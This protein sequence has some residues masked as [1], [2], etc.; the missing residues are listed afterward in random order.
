MIGINQADAHPRLGREDHGDVTIQIEEQRGPMTL[1]LNGYHRIRWHLTGPGVSQIERLVS[2]GYDEQL[3][4][5]PTLEP[6]F[7]EQYIVSHGDSM[8]SRPLPLLSWFD[9]HAGHC[10]AT[11]P[12]KHE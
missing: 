1:V 12:H 4:N 10:G 11:T 2:V 9:P 3:I 7:V 8:G 5:A 6:N